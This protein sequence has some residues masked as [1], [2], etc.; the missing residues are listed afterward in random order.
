[1]KLDRK[2][3]IL[4]CIVEEFVETAKPVGSETLA[5]KYDLDCSAATIRNTM[6]DL[7]KEGFLEKTHT[8]SGRVPSAKAY[9]Y[10]VEKLNSSEALVTTVDIEFQNRFQQILKDKTKSVEDVLSQ[11]CDILSD[12]THMATVVLGPKSYDESLV[13]IQLLRLNENQIMAIFITDSGYVEK[14]TFVFPDSKTVSFDFLTETVKLLNDRLTGTKIAD[15]EEKANALKPIASQMYGDAG[16]LVMNAFMETLLSFTRSRAF[17]HGKKN[18]LDLPE[19]A[20]DREAFLQAVDTLE[21]PE[22]LEH[23]ISHREDVGDSKVGFTN[24]N[25]GDFAVV[26]KPI[27]K[28]SI[29]VVGPKRMDYR[30]ILTA[31]EYVVYMLDK[32]YFSSDDTSKSLVQIDSRNDKEKGDDDE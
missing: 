24:E 2:D 17:V 29:A 4:K 10:Y 9:Q 30:K 20:N 1:M 26:S 21:N 25:S 22:S 6:G 18:L 11:S 15:L 16:S 3:E 14:K 28:D 27:G 32:Y 12:M 5:S 23:S 7:E 8:S 19:F 31:L 13:S